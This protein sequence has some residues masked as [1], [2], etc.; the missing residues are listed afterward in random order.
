MTAVLD[1]VAINSQNLEESIRFFEEVFHMT[2]SRE[3]GT[4]PNRR[5]WFHQ[6]IQINESIDLCR[7]NTLYHHIALRVSDRAKAVETSIK[8]GC[9]MVEGKDNWIVTQ[10]GIVI[11]FMG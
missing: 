8:Y 5:I 3:A 11:E 10:D 6:G 9:T 1:H 4:K 7:E 2:V